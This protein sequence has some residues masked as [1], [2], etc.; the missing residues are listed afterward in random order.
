MATVA[1]A[2]AATVAEEAEAT[3]VGTVTEEETGEEAAETS[4][5]VQTFH[6]HPQSNGTHHTCSTSQSSL[7]HCT[8]Y[9][10]PFLRPKVR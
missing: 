3:E 1:E 6:R 10:E 7:L 2:A 5:T 8:K 9:F 4:V